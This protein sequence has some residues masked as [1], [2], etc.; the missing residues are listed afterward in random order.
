LPNADNSGDRLGK[1]TCLGTGVGDAL[2]YAYNVV[3]HD[4]DEMLMKKKD[5]SECIA[6]TSIFSVE[7]PGIEPVT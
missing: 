6:L 4:V 5:W 3:D 2:C 7:L 1:P